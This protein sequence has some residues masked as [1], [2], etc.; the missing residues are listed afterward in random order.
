MISSKAVGGKDAKL[1]DGERMFRAFSGINRLIF[2][3]AGLY[4]RGAKSAVSH[5]YGSGHRRGNLANGPG[6]EFEIE[7]VWCRLR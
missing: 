7:L 3:N 5:V 4:R 1:L 6:R 2:H